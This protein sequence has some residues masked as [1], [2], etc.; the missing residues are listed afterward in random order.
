MSK[1]RFIAHPTIVN[2]KLQPQATMSLSISGF[3]FTSDSKMGH[4]MDRHIG[5]AEVILDYSHE[6]GAEPEGKA[7]NLQMYLCSNSLLT[8]I[9][10]RQSLNC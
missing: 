8:L 2:K 7:F 6:R 9:L 3:L 1:P 10:F 4:E 5:V